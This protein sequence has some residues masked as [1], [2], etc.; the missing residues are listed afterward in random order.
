MTNTKQDSAPPPT[1]ED[2]ERLAELLDGAIS[3]RSWHQVDWYVLM[4]ARQVVG[5]RIFAMKFGEK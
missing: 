3:E 5:Q 2:M 4:T 1:L